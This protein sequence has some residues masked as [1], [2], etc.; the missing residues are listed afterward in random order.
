MIFHSLEWIFSSL[1]KI[2]LFSALL[3]IVRQQ[4]RWALSFSMDFRLNW[5]CIFIGNRKHSIMVVGSIEVDVH[6]GSNTNSIIA[7]DNILP[8]S[9]F[10]SVCSRMV[11]YPE[12]PYSSWIRNVATIMPGH[13]LCWQQSRD[14]RLFKWIWIFTRSGSNGMEQRGCAH[15]TQISLKNKTRLCDPSY[16]TLIHTCKLAHN[17]KVYDSKKPHNKWRKCVMNAV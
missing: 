9:L 2:L 7:G 13:S 12:H 3:K 11:I 8:R 16:F 6:T 17:L 1:K 14:I 5:H 4:R 15:F 10:L